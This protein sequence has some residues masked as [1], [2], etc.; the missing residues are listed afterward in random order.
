VA[1]AAVGLGLLRWLF[2]ERAMTAVGPRAWLDAGFALALLGLVLLVALGLGRKVRR[3]IAVDG[4]TGLERATFD[5]AVGLGGLGYGV[6]A[7]GLVGT[8]RPETISLWLILVGVWTAREWSEVV[9]AGTDRLTAL[10]REWRGLDWGWRALILLGGGILA[11]TLVQALTPPW[12]YD[13]LLYHLEGPRQF[14]QAER[15]LLLP[16][17]WQA[18]GPFTIEMLFVVGLAW[19][20]DPFARLTHLLYAAL[21]VLATFSF[22]QRYLGPKEGWLA[23]AILVGIPILP[24]WA[25]W[26]YADVAWAVYEFLG[27]YALALWWEKGERRWLALAGVMVGLALGSKYLA[28]GGAAVLGMWVVWRSRAQGW[29]AM[30]GHGLLFGGVALLVGCPWYLKNWAW[31][32]NPI[33]PLF[34]GGPGWTTEQVGWHT[35][36]HRGFG[37]GQT[38]GDYVL[39]PWNLYARREQFGTLGGR[40]E[41]PSLLFPLVLLYPV[42][43]RSSRLMDGVAWV[44]FGRF[45]MWAVGSQQTRFLLP[46]FPALSL[47]TVSVVWGLLRSAGRRWKNALA[48]GLAGGMLVTT[49][50]WSLFT[51]AEIQPLPV[52]L[53]IESKDEFLRRRVDNYA[54]L[55]FV[56]ETLPLHGRVMMMWDAQGYYCDAR[57]LPDSTQ[58]RWA[59]MASAARDVPSVA[60]ELRSMGVTHLLLS[61]ADAEFIAQHD[62]TGR[63]RWALNFF[64]DEFRPACTEQV[65]R[66]DYVHVFELVCSR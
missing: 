9:I 13:A 29:R 60:A 25:S 6:L 10:G 8:L 30:L 12:E 48:I 1:A 4:L 26:A 63:H 50:L 27:L 53:G 18:N 11:L 2:P 31:T 49:L 51:W 7:L 43:R 36:Y 38:V 3:W 5:L 47:L 65:Y 44:T 37:T 52:V 64:L 41:M 57:C 17:N 39:L 16:E 24:V 58:A 54:A 14:L 56:Q 34:W 61:S 19:G 66:D 35:L 59:Q 62:P 23:A 46:L 55:Q 45:G 22:G 28:L 40:I 21:L 32:G 33:Y 15:I 42:T 20:S